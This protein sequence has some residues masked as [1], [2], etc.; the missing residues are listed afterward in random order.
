VTFGEPRAL[1]DISL[2]TLSLSLMKSAA[3]T[4]RA[5]GFVYVTGLLGFLYDQG[6]VRAPEGGGG[7][8]LRA[9]PHE[10]LDDSTRLCG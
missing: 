5:P 6:G 3:F 4:F 2:F 10:A 7:G 8:E 1:V 9:S